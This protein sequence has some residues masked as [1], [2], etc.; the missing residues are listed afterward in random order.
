MN[1]RTETLTGSL[2]AGWKRFLPELGLPSCPHANNRF[3]WRNKPAVLVNGTRYCI[4]K[5]LEH[6]LVDS[7]A[8]VTPLQM[9]S[10]AHRVP[11]GLLLLSRGSL[12]E[13]QLRSA[14]EMQRK[15]GHGYIGEW[16]QRLGY[17]SEEQITS[18]VARQW[19]CPILHSRK[20]N[21][22]TKLAPQI[23]ITL[24]EA[25]MMVPVDYVPAFNTLH[26][27]FSGQPDYRPLYAIKEITG[28]HTEPCMATSAFVRESL[29][30]MKY[31]RPQ[32]EIVFEHVSG[33]TEFARILLSYAAR[34]TPSQI[35]CVNCGSLVWVQFT[36][37]KCAAL[38]FVVN[39]CWTSSDELPFQSA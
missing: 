24:L 37:S 32:N 34:L 4:D 28:C 2:K 23:P 20:V 17:V 33:I 25:F 3:L 21:S 39:A 6:A 13:G 15:E 22:R 18:A 29:A 11:L 26:V 38:D 1:L 35:Q 10:T 7:I 16:L 12:T 9:H 31:Q 5:C 14:L 8:R 36:R 27:A 19:S 30:R